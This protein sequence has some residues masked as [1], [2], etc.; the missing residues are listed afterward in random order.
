MD[1]PS[2]RSQSGSTPEAGSAGPTTTPTVSSYVLLLLILLLGAPPLA[3]QRYHVRSYTIEDGLAQ[4]QPLTILQS[5]SGYLWV[6]T[7]GGGLSRFDGNR[8]TNFTTRDGLPSNNVRSLAE[9]SGGILWI[10]TESGLARYDGTSI[11]PVDAGLDGLIVVALAAGGD[12]AI[13]AGTGDSGLVRVD[14]VT[15]LVRRFTAEDGLAG[16]QVRAIHPLPGGTVWVG[17]TA[18][19]CRWDGKAEDFT[20]YH[21]VDGLPGDT[22]RAIAPGPKGALWFGTDRGPA[23]FDGSRFSSPGYPGLAGLRIDAMARDHSGA[24]WLAT[25]QGLRQVFGAG[26][27]SYTKANGFGDGIYSLH[28]DREDNVWLGTDTDGLTRFAR[29]PFATFDSRHGLPGETVWSITEDRGGAYWITTG[30]GATRFDGRNFTNYTP[31]D[32]LP[33]RV[34][35]SALTDST[36]TT[37]FATAKGIVTFDGR[38]FRPPRGGPFRHNSW[39]LLLDHRGRIWAGTAGD[40]LFRYDAGRWARYST[41]QGLPSNTVNMVTES[42]DG[43][44][45]AATPRGVARLVDTT[46]QALEMPDSLAPID[47]T[48]VLADSVGDLWIATYGS[49][50][51][52]AVAGAHGRPRS[53]TSYRVAEGLSDNN[54]VALVLDDEDGLWVCTNNDLNRLNTR[55]LRATG[56]IHFD[57]FG[58]AQGFTGRE[59][60]SGAAYRDS[61]GQLWFG[62]KGELIRYTPG[63]EPPRLA[64]PRVHL[65]GIRLF[66]ERP[67]WSS[68]SS[69]TVPGTT[70][71]ADLRLAHGDNHLTF[72]FIGISLASPENV[73]YQYMLEGADE[74]WTPPTSETSATYANLPPG[75][76]TF[77][78]RAATGEGPWSEEAEPYG[79][80]ITPPFWFRTWFILGVLGG[81]I[82][83]A[84]GLVRWRERG[85]KLRQA[86]LEQ[87]VRER[88]AELHR[89]KEKVLEANARLEQLSLVARETDSAV[90]IAD[91]AGRIEWINEGCTRTTG[92]TLDA[93]CSQVGATLQEVCAPADIDECIARGLGGGDSSSFES[94]IETTT[95]ST[96]WLSATLTPVTGRDGK[97]TKL[98]VVATDITGHKLLE[99]QLIEAREAALDAARVKADFLANMSHEIRTPMNGVIGMADL[100]AD[101]DLQ[102]EQRELLE[103]IRNS[104]DALLVLIND[105]L[106]FSKIEAGKVVLENQPFELH[107][108]IEEAISLVAPSAA[109]KR[110]ELA[111]FVPATIPHLVAGD[112]TRVRQVL[113]NLLANAVKFTERGEVAVMVEAA[114]VERDRCELLVSVRDTGVG[115][116]ESRIAGLFE[117]FTQVDSSTTRRYGG[118]GL[119]L[120][121]SRRLVHLMGGR[122]WVE[123]EEGAGSTFHFTLSCRIPPDEAALPSSASGALQGRRALL[124][125]DNATNLRMLALQTR[126]WGM[127]AVTAQSGPEAL[128]QLDREPPFD[129]I[130]LD[131]QMPAMDGLTLAGRISRRA[132]DA[133]APLVM[134][135]SLGHRP[136]SRNHDHDPKLAAWLTKPVK[137]DQLY[138][139]LTKLVGNGNRD[140]GSVSELVP[141][142]GHEST[143]AP[144]SILVAE[145]NPI[146]Q[147]V[148]VTLVESLG[149]RP[150]VVANGVAALAAV[151]RR[152]YDIVL[153]DVQMPEM[154]GLEATRRIRDMFPPDRAPR[155]IAT[156][157]NATVD[158][159]EEC[160]AAG[161]DFYL[162]KPIRRAALAEALARYAPGRPEDGPE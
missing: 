104:G 146:N 67:D 74:S 59:C 127:E 23:V 62:A 26:V 70:L 12:G 20:C 100:L 90:F 108:V 118:T 147:K 91:A 150:E 153:M 112:V 54:I 49:G 33:D 143:L 154:D 119:G 30:G 110:L 101:T 11:A 129:V 76:Y 6:G 136:D 132:G 151:Q 57:H 21:P 125:D 120:A 105:I 115:I 8:F 93:L 88:T 71:P 159:R 77:R 61:R 89:E 40:G 34:V 52:H 41:D 58:P 113:T 1:R 157:A 3:A 114:S 17:T 24:M 87:R 78:V 152:H 2:A 81:L 138:G 122:M 27:R 7:L 102:P 53:V 80:V 25:D 31:Q 36:G 162:S 38:R 37:W 123:S 10:G 35:Y 45:W 55:L 75:N 16:L 73:V 126:R 9:D 50:L 134:L 92:Y 72:D 66:F 79:L 5:R 144:V 116:P 13:W 103:V 22:V 139:L 15:N 128:R 117:S 124:V 142:P 141:A 94:A 84:R 82:L 51:V 64:P 28:V 107:L 60:N 56:E 43:V 98:V 140:P 29:S 99:E 156:T 148:I 42:A 46:F 47:A 111:Y 135:S 83:G 161:M 39:T 18:G 106:D 96:V 109:E 48:Y 14:P 133:T 160:L 19:A 155:I 32:G 65:T 97:V 4:S 121:I 44:L 95:G 69:G 86:R 130:V 63:H 85:L 68:R 131:M 137:Q 145:D 158:D 149:Y